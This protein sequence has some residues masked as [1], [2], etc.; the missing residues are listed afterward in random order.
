MGRIF[1]VGSC[2]Q[3][4]WLTGNC[5]PWLV[6]GRSWVSASGGLG[7]GIKLLA[8]LI[9]IQIGILNVGKCFKPNQLNLFSGYTSYRSRIEIDIFLS[10]SLSVLDF[11]N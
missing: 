2:L 11:G 1:V 6:S 7:A 5:F 9:R 4:N 10:W 3:K 8:V